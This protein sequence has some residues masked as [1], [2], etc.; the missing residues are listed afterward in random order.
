MHM[1]GAN[2]IL[3]DFHYCSNSLPEVSMAEVEADSNVA[4]MASV[5]D[6]HNPFRLRNFILHILDQKIDAH[7]PGEGLKVLNRG[8][9]VLKSA[10]AP[11]VFPVTQVNDKIFER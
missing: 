6:L 8:Q 5:Q 2:A 7:W 11:Q 4:E 1:S 9:G 3:Q 10:R